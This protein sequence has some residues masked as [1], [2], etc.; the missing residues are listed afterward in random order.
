MGYLSTNARTDG[1][2][3]K[4]EIKVTRPGLKTR[5]RQGYFAPYRKRP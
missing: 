4:V 5:S 3:R 2:W 1:K